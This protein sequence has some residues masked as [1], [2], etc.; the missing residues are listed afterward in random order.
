MFRAF[1][2]PRHLV[3]FLSVL[4]FDFKF[5]SDWDFLVN[6]SEKSGEIGLELA[7]LPGNLSRSKVVLKPSPISR[8]NEE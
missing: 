4:D 3:D 2:P 1:F 8:E 5:L 6:L 7:R